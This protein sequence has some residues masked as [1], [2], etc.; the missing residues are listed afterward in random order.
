MSE[1]A[2]IIDA[3]G[4]CLMCMGIGWA[5]VVWAINRK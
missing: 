4:F 3:I 5:A 2:Q 1:A